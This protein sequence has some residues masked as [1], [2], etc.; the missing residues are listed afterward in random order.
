MCME[1][2]FNT[3]GRYAMHALCLVS[4]CGLVWACKDDYILDDEKPGSLSSVCTP[5]YKTKATT[6]PTS[7]C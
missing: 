1:N 5:S 2:R 4:F 3:F 7:A 6:R